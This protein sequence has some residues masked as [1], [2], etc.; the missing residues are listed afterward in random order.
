MV[1]FH[2]KLFVIA[3]T[4]I[5]WGEFCGP[6]RC[7]IPLLGKWMEMVWK[8][9]SQP[10]LSWLGLKKKVRAGDWCSIVLIMKPVAFLG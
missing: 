6:W 3:S 2:S 10:T 9:P 7:F 4:M 5:F 1:I 8:S